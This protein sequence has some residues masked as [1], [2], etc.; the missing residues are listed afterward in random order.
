MNWT[1]IWMYLFGTAT[2]WG[3][4]MGFWVSMAVVVMIVLIMNIVFWCM[5]PKEND[6]S[7]GR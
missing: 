1:N 2:L 5:K 4:D 7:H 6:Q 3:L